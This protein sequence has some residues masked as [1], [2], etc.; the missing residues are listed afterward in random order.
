MGAGSSG[1]LDALAPAALFILRDDSLLANSQAEVC[2]APA[3]LDLG[4]TSRVAR[5]NM[6]L[7]WKGRR[8]DHWIGSR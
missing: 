2:L 4:L 5:R 8:F 6:A 7:V 1:E 3:I